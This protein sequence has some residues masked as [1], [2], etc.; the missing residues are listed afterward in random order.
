MADINFS[1]E[2]RLIEIED[3]KTADT[4]GRRIKSLVAVVQNVL[5]KNFGKTINEN[6]IRAICT[7]IQPNELETCIRIANFVIPY[8][9]EKKNW[10]VLSYQVPMVLMANEIFRSNG[11]S[12]FTTAVSPLTKPSQ[13]NALKMDAH[14]FFSL[15]CLSKKGQNLDIFNYDDSV[16]ASRQ[17]ATENKDAVNSSFFNMSLIKRIMENHNQNFARWVIFLPGVKTVRLIGT[18][19][20]YPASKTIRPVKQSSTKSLI[21]SDQSLVIREQSE[22]VK[23]LEED[24]N[25]LKLL[26]TEVLV[27]NGLLKEALKGR[28]LNMHKKEIINLKNGWVLLNHSQELSPEQ[29]NNNTLLYKRINTEKNIRREIHGRVQ[30]LKNQISQLRNEIYLLRQH[31]NTTKNWLDEKESNTITNKLEISRD[32]YKSFEK[33]ENL[34]LN[35]DFLNDTEDVMFSGTDNGFVKMTETSKFNMEKYK[36]H[37]N[38]YNR[39]HILKEDGG[40]LS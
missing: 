32:P 39:F 25:R 28:R 11:Y 12:K 14:S 37:L 21:P 17:I 24:S 35:E 5:F 31:K 10:R 26:Q 29:T 9:L 19:K 8:L 40:K 20:N 2:K 30:N 3:E 7:D 13:L 34:Q 16:I 1:A 22:Q 18:I 27:L 4:S 23:N 33:V 6:H 36:F 15:F 38:L